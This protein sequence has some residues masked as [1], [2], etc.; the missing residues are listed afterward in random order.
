MTRI[1]ELTVEIRKHYADARAAAEE[2]R[3][4]ILELAKSSP[5][6][7]DVEIAAAAGITRQA[8]QRIRSGKPRTS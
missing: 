8:V 6:I 2:R 1:H 4:L 7:T 5:E 3:Q